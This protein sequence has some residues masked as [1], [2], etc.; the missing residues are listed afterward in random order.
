MVKRKLK[1]KIKGLL[2]GTPGFLAI[3]SW[4]TRHTP[5]IFM[6]HRFVAENDKSVHALSRHAFDSYLKYLSRK[7]WNIITLDQYLTK[8]IKGSKIPPYTVI[9]TID[10]GYRD[11]YDVAYPLLK[12]YNLT[13]TFFITTKF[14]DGG[15]WLWH[16]RLHYAI[17]NTLKKQIIINVGGCNQVFNLDN[18]N[19][20]KETWQQLSNYCVSVTNSD[21]WNLIKEVMRA[22]D[23]SI[24]NNVPE[25]YSAVT[26][27][28]VQEL[29][30]YG[31]EI[32]SHTYS[33]PILSQIDSKYLAKEILGSKKI[34]EEKLSI[35][36]NSFCYPN[37]RNEDINEEV[38]NTVIQS[39]YQGATHGC[40]LDFSNLFRIPRMGIGD[41]ENDFYWK[42]SGLE[43]LLNDFE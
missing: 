13:A 43:M 8:R 9:I 4:Y 11:F 39:K 18:E 36:I 22:L 41:D 20:K 33:H 24:P 26:W 16:D 25:A 7:K 32:G 19:N 14:V 30:R 29:Q 12:K 42:L 1:K 23:V 31:I 10:D 6:I 38:I 3:A 37:G 28:Q 40:H 35:P 17:E 2:V 27:A 34:I 21:K 15:F 5:K